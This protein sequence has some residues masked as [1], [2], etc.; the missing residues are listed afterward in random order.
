MGKKIQVT[1]TA[2]LA[3]SI[4]YFFL[5]LAIPFQTHADAEKNI[6][7]DSLGRQVDVP[8]KI[9][10]IACM[11]AFTG[12]VVAMLGRANDI[13]AVSNGLKRDV[14]LKTMYPA[15]REAL[16]PKYQGAINIEE[17]ART[18]PD[19]V[20]IH[21]EIGRNDA[22]TAKLD[23]CGLTWIT[24]EF[25][26]MEQQQ[27]VIALIGQAIGASEKAADY[28]AY[29]RSCIDRARKTVASIPLE[30][31]TRLFHATVEPTR[32]S[33]ENSLPSDWIRTAGVIN[34][35]AQEQTH[36]L[37]GKHQ[38]AIE[39]I[40]LW[41]PDVILANEP[42]VVDFIIKSP[43]WSAIAA[44]ENGRVLQMPIGISRWGHPGSLETPLA[45]LWTVK[46]VYPDFL[47]EINMTS[48]LRHFYK[49]FFNYE[50]SDPMVKQILSGQG[51]RLTKNRKKRQ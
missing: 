41:N 37:D 4:C 36:L 20:F 30:D 48:E 2:V 25:H 1:L 31:R 7:V 21:T 50:L 13:V 22:E 6:L 15:I 29:Y 17:L 23:A 5:S 8:A 38:V 42:G 16:V 47:G 18:K 51:M 35:A 44:V 3:I 45:I 11:Y 43:K 24:V 9:E 26:N 32:T 10:R 28:N 14:L 19:V 12:H 34:V 33:P 27:Q 49:T 46:S 40:L 39:Q